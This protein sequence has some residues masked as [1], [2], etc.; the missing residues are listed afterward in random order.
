MISNYIFKHLSQDVTN[1]TALAVLDDV[2][3]RMNNPD[4]AAGDLPPY[5][6]TSLKTLLGEAANNTTGDGGYPQWAINRILDIKAGRKFVDIEDP[7]NLPL[8]KISVSNL[9]R[10][11]GATAHYRQ[12]ADVVILVQTNPSVVNADSAYN[13]MQRIN[14]LFVT[15]TES[16]IVQQ[17]D[18]AKELTGITGLSNLTIQWVGT[19]DLAWDV[20]RTV[21][22][23]HASVIQ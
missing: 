19:S 5:L 22:R 10:D 20:Q 18:L 8:I 21:Y 2:R 3:T 15:Y 4:L 7:D 13:I 16:G 12:S 6:Y 14:S 9:T 17:R 11:Q 23:A 1:T